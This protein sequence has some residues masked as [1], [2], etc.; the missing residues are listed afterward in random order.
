MQ[1]LTEEQLVS[2]YYHDADAPLSANEHLSE[3]AECRTQYDTIERVLALV[4]EAPVPERS[5][6]YG[7][8]VW[9]RLRWK[10]GSERRR[11]RGW[12]S[13]AAVAAML[14]VAFFAGILWRSRPDRTPAKQ[15]SNLATSQL[16]NPDAQNRILL[17][18]LSDHLDTSER[19]LMEVVNAD[20]EKSLPFDVQQKRAEELVAANRIYRQTAVR[21]GD[22]RLAELLSDLEPVLIQISHTGPNASS[23]TIA[24]LQKR[25]ET[26]QLL[27][28]VRV[29]S[30][31]VTGAEK[32]RGPVNAD[33][34]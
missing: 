14:A 16:R 5:E 23:E 25:I 29:V 26:K 17:V 1:H 15:P 6:R 18:V 21:R 20:P 3:C 12:Q 24:Q 19:V 34:L 10:L 28:K 7:D 4:K 22:D 9:N 31:H 13:L 30:A 33:T 11:Q 32:Q 2:H 27:F 8:E